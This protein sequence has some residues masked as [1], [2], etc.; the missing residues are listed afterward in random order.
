M[1]KDDHETEQSS[2]LGWVWLSR[3]IAVDRRLAQRASGNRATRFIYEFIRFGMKQAWAC[4]FGGAMLALLL[5]TH[6]WYPK[7]ALFAR[8]DFLVLAALSV[9]VGMLVWRLETWEEARVILVFHL[10]GTAMEIFKTRMGS[11]IYPEPS[12]LRLGGVPLFSGFMYAAVGSYIAR[13]WRL[14][15]FQFERYPPLWAT[16]LLAAA[17]YG[18][19]FLHHYWYDLR[20]IILAAFF[21]LFGRTVIWFRVHHHWRWMPVPISTFLVALFIWI[22]ENIGTWSRAWIYPSQSS[23]WS[24]V[25]LSKLSA[26]YLLMIISVVLVTL[27]QK[28]KAFDKRGAE[29]QPNG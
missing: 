23:G 25:P 1:T 7:D 11:W 13:A 27:V 2:A 26:W 24:P 19:F 18:N 20:W 5:A 21:L 9:Q 17:I 4:L 16:W 3:F 6:L 12:L 10:V 29:L 22:G 8:Y 28:P 14:F 15:D